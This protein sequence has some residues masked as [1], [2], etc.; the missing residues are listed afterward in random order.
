MKSKSA[1]LYEVLNVSKTA[2]EGEIRT[3]FKK[4]ARKYHPDMHASKSEEEKKKM[5]DKFK[6]LN[7]A[8]EILTDKKKRDFY[9]QTGM[10]E[11]EA[12]AGYG[13]SA[14]GSSF[15]G[16][17]GFPGGFQFSGF[18]SMGG[19]GMGSGF[20]DFGDIRS[21]FGNGFDSFFDVGGRQKAQA[22]PANNKVLEYKLAVSLEEICNGATKKLSIKRTKTSGSREQ[23]FI[24]VTIAP[25]YKY[26]TKITYKNSGDYNIDGTGTDIVVILTEKPHPIFK[27]SNTDIIYE[28]KITIKEYLNGFTKQILGLKDNPIVIDSNIIGNNSKDAVI[29]GEGIPDRSNGSKRGSLIIKTRIVMDITPREKKEILSALS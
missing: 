9:D 13:G 14:G 8:H 12:Q 3:A 7:N 1:N 19:G 6:E 17:F 4:L 25:G 26:G 15:K 23:T 24:N 10:T 22:S 11:E 16:D 20:H 18:D 28:M 2:T 27:L 29:P 5:Q 21:V